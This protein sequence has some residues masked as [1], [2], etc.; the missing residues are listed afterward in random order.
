MAHLDGCGT[1]AR[2]GGTRILFSKDTAEPRHAKRRPLLQETLAWWE[3]ERHCPE[4]LSAIW[5]DYDLAD[6]AAPT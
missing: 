3:V 5:P 1:L 6:A 2:L 4:A